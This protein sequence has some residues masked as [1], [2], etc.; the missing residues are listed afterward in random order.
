MHKYIHKGG[1]RA[2]V[3][4]AQDYA[5][6][7]TEA[8]D[9]HEGEHLP[10]PPKDEIGE[11][12]EGR[13]ISTS[14]AV[15]RFCSFPLHHNYPSVIRLHIHLPNQQR[16][17]FDELANLTDI[18]EE[19]RETTLTNWLEYNLLHQDGRHLTYA[20][21]PTE[22]TYRESKDQRLFML[23]ISKREGGETVGGWQL[24]LPCLI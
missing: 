2:A 12:L 9:A 18:V 3:R 8:F 16:I 21:F 20:D 24:P 1:D 13:Y 14:E 6:N 15:W 7:D 11:Y 19:R 22:F 10:K 17:T 23:R 5:E 4:I